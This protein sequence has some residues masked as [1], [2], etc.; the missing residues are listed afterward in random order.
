MRDVRALPKA[1]LHLH[2]E[3][4]ARPSTIAEFAA[5]SGIAYEVPT[6][7]ATFA[8]F[9]AA[10]HEMVSYITQPEDVARI[11]REIVEDDAAQGALYTE[12]MMAP[13]FYCER[14]G[15]TEL[16]VFDLMRDAFFEAGRACGVEVGLT[17]AGL[18]PNPIEKTEAAA[19]FAAQQSDQGVVAFNMCSTEPQAG[20]EQWL[21]TRDIIR[22]AGLKMVVHAGEFGP[23]ST[24]DAAMNVLQVDRISHGVRAIEDP[25]V[26]AQLAE[27]Q[28][29]CDVAP[30]SNVILGVFS[31]MNLVPIA[32]FL[33]AGVPFTLNADDELFFRSGVSEE[34][35][36]VR[37]TFGL[38][39]LEVANI[40]RTS[41]QASCASAETKARMLDGID[42]WLSTPA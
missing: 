31:A 26:L 20:H 17:I 28:L 8:E 21:R 24:V 5:R 35:V 12:P 29:V 38:S 37:D 7:F 18:W 4:S 30:S 11:C 32:H 10:Y 3:A 1:H 34:Y 15:M 13:S 22:D 39:D 36:V 14:F 42:A 25:A 40:A 16:E 6:A 9:N 2:F 41:A 19:H 33:E 23:A 27:R